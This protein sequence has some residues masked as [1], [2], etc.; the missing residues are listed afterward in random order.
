M[1]PERNN[2]LVHRQ[3]EKAKEVLKYI[4]EGEK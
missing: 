3:H 1:D 2:E 4:A